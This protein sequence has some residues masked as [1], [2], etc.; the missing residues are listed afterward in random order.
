MS[1]WESLQILREYEAHALPVDALVT[2][3]DWH[4]T[5]YRRTYGT[6]AV[7][8]TSRRNQPGIMSLPL[9]V[10]LFTPLHTRLGQGE[11]HGLLEQLAV[12]VGLQLGPQV[13]PAAYTHPS[14][15]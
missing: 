7:I 9:A 3:M 8:R 15:G 14:Q 13:L 1:D 11:E 6:P 2:D 5:C 12:L 4:H 10:G